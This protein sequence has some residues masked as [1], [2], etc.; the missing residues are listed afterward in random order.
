LNSYD[1]GTGSLTT[2]ISDFWP[3]PHLNAR[4][5]FTYN[6]VGQV[7]TTTDPLGSVTQPG[8]DGAGNQ[9]SIVRD[10]GTGR[11]DQLSSFRYNAAGIDR[12]HD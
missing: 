8:Y 3:S 11:L 10:A 2:S 12:A 6:N 4:R 5:N 7:L 9:T 1:A